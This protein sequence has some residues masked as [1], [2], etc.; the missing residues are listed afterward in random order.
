MCPVVRP[1]GRPVVRPSRCPAVPSSGR[2]V[3]RPSRRP[4]VPSSGS[5]VVRQSRRP[6]VPSSGSPVV[7]Q[8]RRPAVPSSG[9]PVVKAAFEIL[10]HEVTFMYNLSISETQFPENW[11]KALVVPI[12]KQGFLAEVQ[13]YRPISLLSLLG[14]TLEKLIHQQLSKFFEENSLLAEE[15]H[16]F[17]R[18][19]STIHAIS[20]V[21]G[22][23]NK[24]MD[25][26]LATAAVF[27]DFRKAFDCVQHPVLLGKFW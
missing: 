4:A 11:K 2:P 18:N 22:Y 5:P 15:Q 9:S 19:H 13:N 23:I 3:V 12:P 21:T 1:S 16:G 20:Q 8:S 25:A 17:R 10:S 24:K 14:K 6:A 7:R 27:I 26:K